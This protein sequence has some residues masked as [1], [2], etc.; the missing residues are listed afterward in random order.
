MPLERRNSQV[1]VHQV[2][3]AG[4][5]CL[6]KSWDSTDPDSYFGCFQAGPDEAASDVIFGQRVVDDFLNVLDSLKDIQVWD[7]YALVPEGG[8]DNSS[9]HGRHDSKC[10]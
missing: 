4:H 2:L 8:K 5:P 6:E 3:V 7:G 9:C 10:R 1:W